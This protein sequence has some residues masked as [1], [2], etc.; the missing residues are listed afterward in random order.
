[1]PGIN[2]YIVSEGLNNQREFIHYDIM[3]TKIP[4]MAGQLAIELIMGHSQA[5]FHRCQCADHE[6]CGP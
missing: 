6:H 2:R 1:M 5:V 4:N 3:V